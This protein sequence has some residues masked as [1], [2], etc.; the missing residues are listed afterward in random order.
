MKIL[1]TVEFYHPCVGGM[2]EVVKQLSERLARLGH[3][4]TVATGRLAGRSQGRLN[5]VRIEE[6]SVSG[7]LATGM[8]GELERY[9][10][11]V[12]NGDFDVVANFAAQQWA[13][14]ALITMLDRISAVKVFVPTGF[15]GL[16]DPKFKSYFE[17]MP[18][19]LRRYDM[20]VFL[21]EDYRD[22][23]FARDCGADNLVSIPNGASEDEF[24]TDAGIDIRS[25]LAIPRDHLLI[26]QVGSHTGFKGHAEA[27]ATFSRA[28]IEKATLLIVAND[29]GG[30]CSKTCRVKR[31]LF[32]FL[33]GQRV[34][35]KRLLITSLPRAE[36]V[37][38]YRAADLFLF[39]SNIEC[40]PLVLFE[41]LAA[42]TPFLTT[43]VGNAGEIAAWTGGGVVLPTSKDEEGYSRADLPGAARMLEELCLDRARRERLGAAGH[44]A[45]LERFT[46][47]KIAQTYQELYLRLVGEGAGRGQRLGK[48]SS[49]LEKKT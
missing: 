44:G 30:G 18:E 20:N 2:Q 34:R 12:I 25:Q 48:A 24:L 35:G 43:D 16:Y 27:I 33:P 3:D 17:S 14:D 42:R 9:R 31:A 38:A 7:N 29:F 45:W 37:A 10:E 36:T 41:C 11:F 39:P 40:S 26:L 49:R 8:S 46:W 47:G 23:N 21:S 6:F 32:P 22:I 5:G 4:V 1:H 13:T 28:R 15:S 19:W